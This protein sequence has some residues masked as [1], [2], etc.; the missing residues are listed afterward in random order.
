MPYR[1][2]AMYNVVGALLWGAGLTL[3]GFFLGSAI[4]SVD[5]YLLPV[6]ALILFVSV[7]PSA[8][9]L[10]KENGEKIK[11]ITRVQLREI[12]GK[13][14]PEPTPAPTDPSEPTGRG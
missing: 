10:W 8:Y 5:H 12:F 3:L 14:E 2:F 9:H 7:I 6:I 11:Y 4:P 13:G 1:H